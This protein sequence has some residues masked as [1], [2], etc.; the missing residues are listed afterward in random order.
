MHSRTSSM[1][2]D[3]MGVSGESR[4]TGRWACCYWREKYEVL[5]GLPRQAGL[6]S[7]GVLML[8]PPVEDLAQAEGLWDALNQGLGTL[9]D[10]AEEEDL[11]VDQ[12]AFAASIVAQFA[13]RVR[14][15]G[16]TLCR[17]AGQR[18]T[19]DPGPLVA[20]LPADEFA[21][22]LQALAEFLADA[23]GQRKTVTISL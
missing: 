23:A 18:Q 16:S 6:V 14:A 8:P 1:S 4:G 19:H 22:H 2:T 9:I 10:V 15:A 13:G 20:A 3:P 12:L 5:D 11:P 7:P 21:G 17:S